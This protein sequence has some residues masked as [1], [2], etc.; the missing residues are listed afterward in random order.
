MS[1][2]TV[3]DLSC[4]Y[5]RVSVVHNV[6][7]TVEEGEIVSLIGANGAGKST[8]LRTISGVISPVQGKIR[9]REKYIEGRP[10]EEIA[11]LGISHVPEGRGIFPGLTVMENLEV[12]AAWRRLSKSDFQLGV[13]HAFELSPSLERLQTSNGWSLSG[14]E[15]QMLAIGRALMARPDL[16][17]LDEPSMGLAPNLVMQLFQRILEINR[18]GTAILLVEQNAYLAMKM[19]KR[20]YVLESGRLVLSGSSMELAKDS[21]VRE[22]YLG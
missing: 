8:M 15:Q 19:S 13:R 10:A 17:L 16:L 2:L 14:G 1:F 21:R 22:R 20:T 11:R 3:D 4:A 18:M 12:A 6:T 7:L 5:G 9:Y